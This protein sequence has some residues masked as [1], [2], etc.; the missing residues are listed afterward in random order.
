MLCGVYTLH[1]LDHCVFDESYFG[2]PY[3]FGKRKIRLLH[4]HHFVLK[5]LDTRQDL[6]Y[7]RSHPFHQSP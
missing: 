3:V 6:S 5:H 2:R 4:K 7:V 1:L